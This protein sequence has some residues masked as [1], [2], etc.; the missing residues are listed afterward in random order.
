M[1]MSDIASGGVFLVQDTRSEY[2]SET[3][4]S[5]KK[6]KIRDTIKRF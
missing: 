1:G 4:P 3:Q 6:H 5:R 2:Q